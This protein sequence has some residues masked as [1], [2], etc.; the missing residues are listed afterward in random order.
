MGALLLLATSSLCETFEDGG[1]D[2]LLG[3]VCFLESLVD[4]L[5]LVVTGELM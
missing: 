4:V 2:S 1:R 3:A 5:F